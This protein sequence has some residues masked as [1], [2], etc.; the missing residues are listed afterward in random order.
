LFR[1]PELAR[2]YALSSNILYSALNCIENLFT[3]AQVPSPILIHYIFV[4]VLTPDIFSVFLPEITKEWTSTK[5]QEGV[6]T[7]LSLLLSF[8]VCLFSEFTRVTPASQ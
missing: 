4:L 2:R 1:A 5:V 3:K 6:Y 8:V 7:P